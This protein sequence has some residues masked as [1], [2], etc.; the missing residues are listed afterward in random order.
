MERQEDTL[1]ED[2][3]S[4]TQ[5]FHDN[6]TNVATVIE[7]M[8]AKTH[9]VYDEACSFKKYSLYQTKLILIKIILSYDQYIHLNKHFQL[10]ALDK[11]KL[12]LAGIY[13]M[14]ALFRVYLIT[15]GIDPKEHEIGQELNRIKKTMNRV[16]DIE[17]KLSRAKVNTGAAKRLIRNAMWDKAHKKSDKDPKKDSANDRK[18]NKVSKEKK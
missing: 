14:N 7:E 15:K 18:T 3:I 8:Q 5:E 2:V 6:L 13:S 4:K 12:D 17:E 9:K 16:K 10:S 1:P 11:A